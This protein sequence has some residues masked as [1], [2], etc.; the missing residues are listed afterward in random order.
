[1]GGTVGKGNGASVGG[2]IGSQIVS[3]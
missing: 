3:L 2:A 1:M